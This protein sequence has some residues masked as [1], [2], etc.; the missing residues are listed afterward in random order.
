[1]GWA[2][3]FEFYPERNGGAELVSKYEDLGQ[4]R[5]DNSTGLD[6][7]TK[8]INYIAVPGSDRGKKNLRKM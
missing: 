7:L 5:A 6:V 4:L 3:I 1:M 8:L 2:F